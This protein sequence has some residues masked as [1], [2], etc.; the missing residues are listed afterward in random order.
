MMNML[1]KYI[2]FPRK[3][4]LYSPPHTP[5]PTPSP[6]GNNSYWSRSGGGALLCTSQSLACCFYNVNVHGTHLAYFDSKPLGWVGWEFAF[7]LSS[8]GTAC[9]WPG[10]HAMKFMKCMLCVHEHVSMWLFSMVPVTSYWRAEVAPSPGWVSSRS[11]SCSHSLVF[12]LWMEQI[13][14]LSYC[15][16]ARGEGIGGGCGG[17]ATLLYRDIE[18]TASCPLLLSLTLSVLISDESL[19]LLP[20]RDIRAKTI[21]VLLWGNK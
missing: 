21:W 2:P 5:S 7:Q 10:S 17:A 6:R 16:R 13:V 11:H 14:S 18:A 8:W 20:I 19:A 9:P 4:V 3:E 12:S 15:T 1:L